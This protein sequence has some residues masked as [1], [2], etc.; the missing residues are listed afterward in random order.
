MKH[1]SLRRFAFGLMAAAGIVAGALIPQDPD[2]KQLAVE[3]YE[4]AQQVWGHLEKSWETAAEVDTRALWSR[5]LAE[6]AAESGAVPARDAFAQH[7]A[8]MQEMI[9]VVKAR[10][11]A[12][13]SSAADLAV[14]EFHVAEAKLLAKR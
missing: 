10:Q 5:R 14:V 2:A 9:V 1:A 4:A 8:R 3:R 6:A 11:E 7:L 12:G 13:R